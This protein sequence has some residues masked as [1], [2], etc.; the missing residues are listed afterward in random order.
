MKIKLEVESTDYD[1]LDTMT[2]ML[3]VHEILSSI[4]D[5]KLLIRNRL[6]HGENVS[7]LEEA[8]LL[9]IRDALYINIL[10]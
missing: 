1:D 3:H 7:D 6:K 5:A 4:H 10:E 2:S 8:S 9:R